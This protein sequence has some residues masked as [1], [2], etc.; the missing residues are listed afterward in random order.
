MDRPFTP[1][2]D[3][4]EPD[5]PESTSTDP[6]GT[7]T[8]TSTPKRETDSGLSLRI[9]ALA[10]QRSSG[11]SSASLP[12]LTPRELKYDGSI[13]EWNLISAGPSMMQVKPADLLQGGTTIAINRAISIRN[14]VPVDIWACWDDPERLFRL[15]YG[16]H[17]YPPLTV[18]VGP[19]QFFHFY[20][21]GMRGFDPPEW[22]RFLHPEIGLRCMPWGV[23]DYDHAQ[24]GPVGKTVFTLIYAIEKAVDLGARHIR[25]MGVDMEGSWIDN[26]T[27]EECVGA[28]GDRWV[29]ER[30]K[31]EDC[32]HAAETECQ[33]FIE[34]I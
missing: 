2:P 30:E 20:E 12:K 33:V 8:S 29:W 19:R 9:Q 21:A 5:T 32:I 18:W 3:V 27:E 1:S 26:Q 17:I 13:P 16:E 7:E 4:S 15:G 14:R 31:L 6:T 28:F 34:R 23:H 10:G 25:L 24:L 11:S 22:E